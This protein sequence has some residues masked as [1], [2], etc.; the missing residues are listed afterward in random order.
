MGLL[1]SAIV[2]RR[3]HRR[4]ALQLSASSSVRGFGLSRGGGRVFA[5]REIGRISR[6]AESALS[7]TPSAPSHPTW[8]ISCASIGPIL[9]GPASVL[10]SACCPAAGPASLPSRPT[11]SEEARR[12]R[13]AS[14]GRYR[15][16]GRAGIRQQRD[17]QCKFIPIL[18]WGFRRA[19]DGADAGAA[20]HPRASTR[21]EVLTQPAGAVL[22]RLASMLDRQPEMLVVLNRPMSGRGVKRSRCPTACLFPPS[23]PSRRSRLRVNSSAFE[24]YLTRVSS[25]SRAS[26]SASSAFPRPHAARSCSAE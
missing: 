5:V 9:R 16:R 24:I 22:G 8:T 12:D 18:R 19:R 15:G 25:W 7:S 1:A 26:C 3:Q 4:A 2:A 13:R 17:A 23:W 21:P 6:S 11:W 10:L 20:H 14:A